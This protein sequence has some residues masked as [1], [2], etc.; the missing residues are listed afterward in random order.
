M[1]GHLGCGAGRVAPAPQPR[2][3]VRGKEACST[4]SAKRAALY[5]KLIT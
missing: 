3:D 4:S 5:E 2:A 1:A